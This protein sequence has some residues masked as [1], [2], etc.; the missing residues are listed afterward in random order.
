V[1]LLGLLV[2]GDDVYWL[3]SCGGAS[4]AVREPIGFCVVGE[5]ELVFAPPQVG[6]LCEFELLFESFFFRLPNMVVFGL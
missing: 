5:V 3:L 4:P 1:N 2:A 6:S